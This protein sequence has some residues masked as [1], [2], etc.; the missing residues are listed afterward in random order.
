MNV[1]LI[2]QMPEGF[3]LAEGNSVVRNQNRF[4]DKLGRNTQVYGW[5]GNAIIIS[6]QTLNMKLLSLCTQA[7]IYERCY[8]FVS[9]GNVRGIT[10]ATRM[11]IKE[12]G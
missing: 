12:P 11:A 8:T 3:L 4:R 2:S 1:L 5:K 7:Q 10:A 6:K 9:Q